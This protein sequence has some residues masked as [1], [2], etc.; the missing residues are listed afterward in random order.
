MA[1]VI[2]EKRS[3]RRRKKIIYKLYT[4]SESNHFAG[5]EEFKFSVNVEQVECECARARRF[6]SWWGFVIFEI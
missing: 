2:D 3:E 4:A 5:E 1:K 6:H